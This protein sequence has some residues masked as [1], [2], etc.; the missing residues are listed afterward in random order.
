MKGWSA[1]LSGILF[2]VAASLLP[3]VSADPDSSTD[4]SEQKNATNSGKQDQNISELIKKLNAKY[5]STRLK[6]RKQ[7]VK[8]GKKAVPELIESAKS[9]PFRTRKNAIIALGKIQDKRSLPVLIKQYTSENVDLRVASRKAIE[10]F[11]LKA[12]DA[13][14]EYTR[15]KPSLEKN[16]K[17]LKKRLV[18]LRIE[19]TLI[20][21]ISD[22]NGHGF[23]EGQFKEIKE[24]G[25]E[26]VPILKKIA[27]G[28][29]EFT[30][31]LPPRVR[32]IQK[33]YSFSTNPINRM[34]VD[35]IGVVG[36]EDDIPF[37][38]KLVGD[39]P[40]AKGL[41]EAASV[42]LFKLGH[43][44][45]LRKLKK[46]LKKLY[47]SAKRNK[48]SGFLTRIG[49]D[50]AMILAR[51]GKNKTAIK[52]YKHL[53]NE[54]DP[55]NMLRGRNQQLW[56]YNL[57]CSYAQTGNKKKALKALENAIKNGYRDVGWVEIDGDLDPIRDMKRFEKMKR[58]MKGEKPILTGPESKDEKEP[59]NEEQSDSENDQD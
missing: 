51:M 58:K 21:E 9:G 8:L 44:K 46:R 20:N 27:L 55:A 24:L 42:A 18:R 36:S 11:G 25:G 59:N 57:A 40:T 32:K 23:Y 16:I 34:A 15:K 31:S 52:V 49:N 14:M 30:Q 54:L 4:S 47:T 22:E 43:K 28:E 3:G 29:Y 45:P 5:L 1:M 38:K 39:R 26:A 33:I 17:E 12:L 53:L 19:N 41:K 48:Q 7:L 35:A 10:S 37:L 2:I 13:L 50:Y 6:A 56:W